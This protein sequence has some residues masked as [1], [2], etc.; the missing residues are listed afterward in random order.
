[1]IVSVKRIILTLLIALIYC[2]IWQVLELILYGEVQYKKIDD[3]I[4]LLFIPVIYL[5]TK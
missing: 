5:A 4:M 3:I 2:L 1:M